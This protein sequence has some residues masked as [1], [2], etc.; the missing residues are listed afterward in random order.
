MAAIKQ[1]PSLAWLFS[2]GPS[3]V[4]IYLIEKKLWEPMSKRNNPR[5]PK[6]VRANNSPSL[7]TI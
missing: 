3:A 1:P 7:S 6:C 2:F 5:K 4:F